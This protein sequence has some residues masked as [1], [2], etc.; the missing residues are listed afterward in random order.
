MDTV[1]RTCKGKVMVSINDHPDI[2]RAFEGFTMMELDIKYSIG[3]THGQPSISRELVITNWE[4]DVV[5]QLF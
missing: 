3:S 4:A 2:R 1:M 5:T